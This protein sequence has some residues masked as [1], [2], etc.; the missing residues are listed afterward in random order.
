MTGDGADIPLQIGVL[1]DSI[2]G[3]TPGVGPVLA[4][5][6]FG[7]LTVWYLDSQ[8]LPIL[9]EEF[10]G[11]IRG[12]VVVGLTAGLVLTVSSLVLQTGYLWLFL[13]V[14]LVLGKFIEAAV[15][16]RLVQ[17]LRSRLRSARRRK[18]ST[19]SVGDALRRRYPP[20][21]ILAAVVLPVAGV[22]LTIVFLGRVSSRSV[23]GDAS[24]VWTVAV[25]V[26]AASGL[27]WDL[28]D[29]I[30]R[31]DGI[32]SLGL[33]FCVM[34]AELYNFSTMPAWLV[35]LIGT[36]LDA[37]PLVRPMPFTEALLTNTALLLVGQAAFAVGFVI[38]LALLT[39]Q[40]RS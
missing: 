14:Y 7:L 39:S 28:R 29:S 36:V 13:L 17:R 1:V 2:V 37:V 19:A 23:L 9:G 6:G 32:P 31:D 26:L 22:V 35:A 12:L 20:S 8:L 24:V 16:V 27:L 18:A 4:I 30:G 40:V 5:L 15:A 11:T 25:G 34:G 10:S 21:R 38:A 3:Y 33:V